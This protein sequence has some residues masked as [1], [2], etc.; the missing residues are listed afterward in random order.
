M[1]S[2]LRDPRSCARL[3]A[4]AAFAMLASSS[5]GLPAF[6][7]AVTIGD[8]TFNSQ[9]WDMTLFWTEGLGGTEVGYQI[10]DGGNPGTYRGIEVQYAT[11]K[12]G[13]NRVTG[14]HRYIPQTYTPSSDGAIMSVDYSEEGKLLQG[15]DQGQGAG[16]A[17][18]QGGRIFISSALWVY[19]DSSWV[20]HAPTGQ[21][22]ADFY[23]PTDPTQHPDFSA[24]GGEIEF[25]FW[26]GNSGHANDPYVSVAGIDNWKFVLHTESAT[27]SV[28]T[29]WG[30]IKALFH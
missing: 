23:D 28:K 21:S 19:P 18:R 20:Q 7:A 1:F 26:R 29:S 27:P 6:A 17:L 8:G 30:G 22:A 25:G 15:Y 13:Y 14:F 4:M 3:A 16:P 5:L 9:D 10:L 2:K 24:S 11:S 12:E